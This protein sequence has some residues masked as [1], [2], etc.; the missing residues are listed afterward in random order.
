MYPKSFLNGC[1]PGRIARHCPSRLYL[2]KS[3]RMRTCLSLLSSRSFATERDNMLDH[4]ALCGNCREVIT[5]ALPAV[6]LAAVPIT[7]ESEPDRGAPVLA[8][9]A[10]SWLKFAWPVCA[11]PH[12]PGIVV[13]ASL[14][15]VHPGRL[16]QAVLPAANRQVATPQPPVSGPQIASSAVP[17]SPIATPSVQQSTIRPKTNDTQLKAKKQL[18]RKSA[19]QAVHDDELPTS[20]HQP[21]S[22]ETVAVVA[23][24][25]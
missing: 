7:A 20:S 1:G 15:M 14:L 12:W 13:V 25:H 24:A 11:G 4:L 21:P 5:L 18:V 23:Q 2:R 6:D 9:P 16:N 10:R 22:G 8:R 19:S 3:T 17:S